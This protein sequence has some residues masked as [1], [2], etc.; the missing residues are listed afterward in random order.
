MVEHPYKEEH[1]DNLYI[2]TFRPYQKDL[3]W[4]F[5]IEDR[6][7]YIDKETDWKIQFDN[8]IPQYICNDMFIPKMTYHRLII[9]K[10][11]LTVKIKKVL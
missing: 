2:R 3:I 5:D 7:I 9:G 4:H 10:D 8:C 6:I 1:V 11:E